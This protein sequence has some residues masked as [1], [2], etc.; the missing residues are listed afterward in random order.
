MKELTNQ[1]LD[2]VDDPP[3]MQGLLEDFR[4]FLLEPLEDEDG[5][6]HPNQSRAERFASYRANLNGR[7]EQSKHPSVRT[8]LEA[9]RDFVMECE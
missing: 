9:M 7:I 2:K 6:T 5:V 4:D 1:L 3:A 8:I